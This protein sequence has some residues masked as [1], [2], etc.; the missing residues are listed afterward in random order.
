MAD[1]IDT[2]AIRERAQ[3]WLTRLAHKRDPADA[4]AAQREFVA[5]LD[6]N[7]R[8]YVALCDEVDRLRRALADIRADTS[9]AGARIIAEDALR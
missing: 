1:R 4:Y 7:I 8:T 5:A 9:D 6:E 3:S 2:D